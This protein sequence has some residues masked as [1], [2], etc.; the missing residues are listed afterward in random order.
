MITE[1]LSPLLTVLSALEVAIPHLA[2]QEELTLHIVGIEDREVR[3]TRVYEE[4][5]HFLPRLKHLRIFYVGPTPGFGIPSKTTTNS[6]CAICQSRRRVRACSFH[7]RD[8][9][10]FL[11]EEELK[12]PFKKPNLIIGFNTGMTEVES[13][14]WKTAVDEMLRLQ[15]P[16]LF[17]AYSL[18]EAKMEAM[19]FEAKTNV[20][21]LLPVERNKWRGVVPTIN[22]MNKFF[23]KTVKVLP[24]PVII[25]TWYRESVVHR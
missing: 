18:P 8:Y 10:T 6:A 22:I 21:F 3:G 4:L 20:K 11:R 1:A 13:E 19:M 15:V 5:L 17:T 7:I 23:L 25:D 2:Q 12:G 14:S 24:M 9:R 16:V